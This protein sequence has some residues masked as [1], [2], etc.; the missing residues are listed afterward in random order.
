MNGPTKKVRRVEFLNVLNPPTLTGEIVQ[1]AP[2]SPNL[3]PPGPLIPL[4]TD[5]LAE[6]CDPL[7]ID[8]T[9]VTES[10][11]KMM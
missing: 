6:I 9:T 1:K 10:K 8:L 2:G 4:R 3:P 11:G 7:Q 5:H